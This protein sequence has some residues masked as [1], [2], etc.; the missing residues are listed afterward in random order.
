MSKKHEE[1]KETA[2]E[3]HDSKAGAVAAPLDV[4][5]DAGGGFEAADKAAYAIPFLSIIQA[6]SPQLKKGNAKYIDGSEEGDIFNSVTN[7]LF[8]AE[9]GLLVIPCFYKQEYIEWADRKNPRPGEGT[10]PFNTFPPHHPII[11]ATPAVN[12]ARTLENGHILSD[13]REHFVMVLNT[14]GRVSPA[15]IT[16]SSTQVKRSM[17][18]MSIMH[19]QKMTGSRGN[20]FTP[21]MFAIVY[22][23]STHNE[24]NKR[25]QSWKG[26]AIKKYGTVDNP[27]LYAM[28]RKFRDDVKVGAVKT[29]EPLADAEAETDETPF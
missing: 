8:K 24:E 1:K 15:V 28:C 26:Y 27:D 29:A 20:V 6:L 25:G 2:V 14:D 22:H 4:E 5:G 13:T 7:D 19:E 18:W 16:M 3:K 17:Q 11:A 12:G 10:G 9:K 21:P 23:I